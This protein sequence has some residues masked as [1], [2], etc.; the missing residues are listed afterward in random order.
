VPRKKGRFKVGPVKLSS[1]NRSAGSPITILVSDSH[2]G[3]P[4]SSTSQG[5]RGGKQI[6]VG[7]NYEVF[8]RLDVDKKKVFLGDV[9]LLN[10]RVFVRGEVV[11]LATEE[12]KFD[13]FMSNKA[14]PIK[15]IWRRSMEK[16][17]TSTKSLIFCI[18]FRRGKKR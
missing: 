11:Q 18:Q 1:S 3:V 16:G 13:G 2:A 12:P 7:A 4:A 15:N 5:S 10:L 8:C 9:L 14:G 6:A 17:I